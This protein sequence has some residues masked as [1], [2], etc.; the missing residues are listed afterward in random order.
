M[1]TDCTFHLRLDP[2]SNRTT[3]SR[4]PVSDV[5]PAVMLGGRGKRWAVWKLLLVTFRSCSDSL[6]A[7]VSTV[8]RFL[9]TAEITAL[10]AGPAVCTGYL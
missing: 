6:E 7:D 2:N 8:I 5:V 10:V 4:S 9:M 3:V 1:N